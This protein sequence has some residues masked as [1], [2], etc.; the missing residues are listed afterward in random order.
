MRLRNCAKHN[1]PVKILS[2]TKKKDKPLYLVGFENSKTHQRSI[3][4]V[5]HKDLAKR[6]P[7]LLVDYLAEII[8]HV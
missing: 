6:Q 8:N 3:F 2:H 4:F 1:K 7:R 5:S